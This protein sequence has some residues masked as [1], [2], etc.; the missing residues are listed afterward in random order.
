MQDRIIKNIFSLSGLSISI[1]VLGFISGIVQ[2]FIDISA[3]ISVKW[4]LLCLLLLISIILILL[5]VVY[6]LVVENISISD[7]QK[8]NNLIETPIR[9]V[10]DNPKG[11]IFLVRKNKNF[12]NNMVVSGY[13]KN[14]ELDNLLFMG[15]VYVIQDKFTQIK[16][17]RW[18][19][20]PDIFDDEKNIRLGIISSIEIRAT[21]PLEFI[22]EER[23]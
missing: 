3:L 13:L 21:I 4:I 9:F 19:D 12:T 20:E 14:N 10:A 6:D 5:K 7:R 15:Y 18:F 22:F 1:G 17:V 2:L 16:I 11:D 8:E 23:E